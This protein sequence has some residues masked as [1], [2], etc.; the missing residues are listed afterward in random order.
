MP[1]LAVCAFRDVLEDSENGCG[2]ER[3]ALLDR[4]FA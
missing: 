2:P 1:R 3:S 4:A